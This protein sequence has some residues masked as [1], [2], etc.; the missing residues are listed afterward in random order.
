MWMNG[1][2]AQVR[3]PPQ[4]NRADALIFEDQ[5]AGAKSH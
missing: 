2:R 3:A 5:N 4:K 1:L